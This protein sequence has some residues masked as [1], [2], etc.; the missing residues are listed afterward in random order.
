MHSRVLIAI[1]IPFLAIACEPTPDSKPS[2][3]RSA[4]KIT[5]FAAASTTDVMIEAGRRFESATMIELVFSFDS[6]SN[7]ARQ[8]KAG[9][10]AD[11]FLSADERWMDDVESAGFIRSDTRRELLSNQLV[12]VAP[13]GR[14]FEVTMTPD[15]DFAERLPDIQRIAV[16]DPAHVPAGRYARQALESLG[17][18]SACRDRLVPALDV[19]AAL[20]LV[21]LGEVDAGIVYVT[22][23]RQSQRVDLVAAFPQKTHDPIRYSTAMCKGGSPEAARFL[24]FLG[25]EEMRNVFE[26]AGFLVLPVEPRQES[27]EP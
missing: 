3:R 6:T 8:I 4:D 22:D 18:W 13:V 25:T 21:E 7:L 19:R 24:T 26:R 10:P 14:R 16:G 27:E 2:E 23:T 9:A 11:V 12:L 17:W 1:L 5:I 20:K 15:F